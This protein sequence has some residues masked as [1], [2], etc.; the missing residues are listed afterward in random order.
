[1]FA[2]LAALALAAVPADD[3]YF[4]WV[5]E[6]VDIQSLPAS[7]VTEL[8]DDELAALTDGQPTLPF[9]EA[10]VGLRTPAGDVWVGSPH[11]LQLLA[12]DATRW[13]VFHSQRWLPSDDVRQL[14]LATD[15]SLLVRTSGGTVRFR[16][17]EISLEA[18]MNAID[19]ML[20]RY[21]VRSGFVSEISLPT[22]GDLSTAQMQESN[23]NDGLWTCMYLAG[24]AFRYGSTGDP[25]A[26]QNA[27]RSLEAIMFLER[28][29]TIPGF[30][31]R[32]V[33]PRESDPK[34]HG[35]EWHPSADGKWWWKADTSSDEVV[36]HYFAYHVYY[37]V[38]AD[39]AERAEIRPYVE[40]ITDHILDH[41]LHYVG[42]PGKPTTWGVWSP[43]G[44][45]HDLRRIG[46]RG[47]NSLEILSHLKV[48]E[49]IVGKPRY[50]EKLKELIAEHGYATNTV[51]QKQVWPPHLVNHSDDELAFLA[52]YPL[53]VL[54]RDV[55][56]R[57]VYLA[58]VRRS[59]MIERPEHSP[60]FNYIYAAA[61]QAN[62]WFDPSK[63]P[64]QA[65]VAPAEYDAA[66][67]LDWFRDVPSDTTVWTVKNSHRR[68]ITLVGNNR[69]RRP[70]GMNVLPASERRVM[71][72]NGDPYTL[73]G[74][75]GGRERDD[76]HAILLPYW[77]GRYHRFLE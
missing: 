6:P 76:G 65:Y 13:R 9:A 73:D 10:T 59:W 41:G 71:R 38:A 34:R 29:S 55:H 2:L 43:E 40:R 50:T 16:R 72:W 1:M 47:L 14:S 68:D 5:A 21:H 57:K 18:K 17:E 15:G 4:A 46:D 48:A 3:T 37:N 45:N 23:D 77:M 66:E 74:G 52:Y 30:V 8:D 75:S 11:G 33:I 19:E 51:L 24:E 35:G 7:A 60:L 26:K 56:L 63:R 69:E 27:R 20:Q 31:A 53:V 22:P 64:D 28:V 32:S 61:L 54:E 67:S 36:G 12:R 44:L 42:P 62:T 39:D 49:Q 25:Q 70:R 58:S